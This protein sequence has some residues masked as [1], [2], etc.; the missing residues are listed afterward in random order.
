MPQNRRV[1]PKG[2]VRARERR[3]LQ[4]GGNAFTGY[5]LPRLAAGQRWQGLLCESR[6]HFPQEQRLSL[7]TIVSILCTLTTAFAE[8]SEV[9]S[10]WENAV[11][12]GVFERIKKCLF[13]IRSQLL[14]PA[15]LRG[16]AI[17]GVA[18]ILALEKDVKLVEKVHGIMGM[19]LIQFSHQ[20]T[21]ELRLQPWYKVDIGNGWSSRMIVTAP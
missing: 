13:L 7:T 16:R 8:L 15:E 3:R 4:R 17:A 1:R 6:K 11:Y 5:F 19:R 14:Y 2:Y 20:W 12:F 9:G 10:V 21:S 18:I